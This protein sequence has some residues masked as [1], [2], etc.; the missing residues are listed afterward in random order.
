MSWQDGDAEYHCPC[1]NGLFDA[2]GR[3]IGGPPPRP[4]D[5]YEY[6]VEDGVLFAGRL[7]RVNED[8]ERI[9]T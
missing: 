7:Y 9:T 3:V 8:L 4:L 2:E 1:H 6:K 5:R